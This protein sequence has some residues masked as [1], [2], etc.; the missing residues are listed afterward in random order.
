MSLF[1]STIDITSQFRARSFAWP[2]LATVKMARIARFAGLQLL[3]DQSP[4]C[5][6]TVGHSKL[7][8]PALMAGRMQIPCYTER[9][10][11]SLLRSD[12]VGSSHT[13]WFTKVARACE[14]R[15]GS[16]SESAAV[17]VGH[18]KIGQGSTLIRRR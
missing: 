17:E 8:A 7:I 13:R 12:I 18:A 4:E 2:L 5:L 9:R 15:A 1:A 10:G 6:M 14:A 11:E 3:E 16:V